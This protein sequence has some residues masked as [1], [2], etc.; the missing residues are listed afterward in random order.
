MGSIIALVVAVVSALVAWALDRRRRVYA[1]QPTTPAAAV[2]AGYNEVVG[3]AYAR[4]PLISKRTQTPSVE[5]SYLLEEE[6][7]HTRTVSETDSNG[8]SSSRTETYEQ[9]HNI[10]QDG[11]Q[12][13]AMEVRDQSGSVWI[14]TEG[15]KL[16]PRQ[17]YREEFRRDDDR[18]FFAKMGDNRTGKYRETER[19]IAVNDELFVVG[20]A[21]LD[22]DT[23]VPYLAKGDAGPFMIST[24][25]EDSHTGNL[26]S[27]VVFL[28]VIFAIAT[29][30]ANVFAFDEPSLD[31]AQTWLPGVVVALL[32]LFFAT[33]IVTFNRLQTVGQAA[34]RAWSLIDVQLERRASLIPN[35]ASLIGAYVEHEKATLEAVTTERSTLPKSDEVTE[36]GQTA[37]TQTSTLRKVIATIEQTPALKANENFGKMMADLIDTENRIAGA[38]TFYNDS[39]TLMRDRRD[40]FPGGLVARL[41][42]APARELFLPNGFERST[43]QIDL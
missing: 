7:R 10:E 11:R 29:V 6:R 33:W 5:W 20:T 13:A 22:T 21:F 41:S 9:W 28:V 32:G 19:G 30:A 39:V 43:P 40:T 34:R 15:A 38:R 31:R 4:Q 42:P 37:E 8:R 1:D 26:G 14:R 16:V 18:G 36:A 35:L 12:L 2:F 24:K 3:T 17:F 23:A 27:G 25:S